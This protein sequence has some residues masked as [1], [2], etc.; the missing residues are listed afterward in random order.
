LQINQVT[1]AS[2]SVAP[3]KTDLSNEE[4]IKA[5]IETYFTIRYEGQKSIVAQDFS[6]LVQDDTSEWVK[7]E[8]DKREIELY[9]ADLFNLG[10]QSYKYYLDYDSIKIDGDQ[11]IVQLR[12]SHQV[13]FNAIAPEVSYMSNLK[14]TI[15]LINE[16]D[17]WVISKDDYQD[18]LSGLID[19]AS[20]G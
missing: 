6:F 12:E 9:I 3:Q 1:T 19:S 8:R 18:D 13:V 16:K 11:A 14:H 4:Q 7:K 10:Y 2:R 17:G 15:T 20:I 5:V